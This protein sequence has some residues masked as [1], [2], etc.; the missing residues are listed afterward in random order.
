MMHAWDIQFAWN[1]WLSI[2]VHID[3]ADPSVTIHLPGL[4]VYAGRCKQPGLRK[5]STWEI[6]AR[7]FEEGRMSVDEMRRQE[8]LGGG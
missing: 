7:E 6:Q 8:L 2:G 1:P 5:P 3:H 4:I